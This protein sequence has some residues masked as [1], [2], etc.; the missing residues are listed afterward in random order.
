MA[1]TPGPW[2][3]EVIDEKELALYSESDPYGVANSILTVDR[4]DACIKN[5][6]LCMWP[7]K[8]NEALIAAA[9]DLLA[10]CKAAQIALDDYTFEQKENGEVSPRWMYELANQLRAAIAQAEVRDD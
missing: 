6:R 7:S 9:P 1:H 3:W 5:D 10:A 8:E 2:K 4:C